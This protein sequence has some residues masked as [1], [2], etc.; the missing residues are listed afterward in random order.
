MD[1]ANLTLPKSPF[2]TRGGAKAPHRKNTL[3]SESVTM[4][5]PKQVILPMV[6]HIGAPCKPV[7]KAGT[8]VAV[9]D[10]IAESEGFVSAPIH[11]TVSGKVSKITQVIS[12][13]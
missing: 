13:R 1:K 5:C 2:R 10:V 3:N 11:A 9:G 4:P 12:L 7:V 8:L 6:Q